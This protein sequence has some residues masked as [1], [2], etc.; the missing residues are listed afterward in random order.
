M[1]AIWG[2]VYVS[3]VIEVVLEQRRR[4][5]H[6]PARLH[7]LGDHRVGARRLGRAGVLR[8]PAPVDPRPRGQAPR[9][10]PEGHHGIGR[11]RGLAKVAEVLDEWR[12]RP[13]P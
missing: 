7:P 2:D 4:P 9:P 6:V 5:A 1:D 11:R 3:R 8:R 12:A 13:D 10:P